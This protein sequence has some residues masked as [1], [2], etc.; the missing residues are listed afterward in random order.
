MFT[1][2]TCTIDLLC[3]QKLQ[4]RVKSSPSLDGLPQNFD[5]NN[6]NLINDQYFKEKNYKPL[7]DGS[8]EN[9]NYIELPTLKVGEY[10][11]YIYAWD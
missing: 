5:L 10:F 4:Y 1:D 11:F 2:V 8:P 7:Q 3:C 6:H 9:Q